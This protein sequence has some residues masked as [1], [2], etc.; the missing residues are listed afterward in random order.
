MQEFKACASFV[1]LTFFI[2][3]FVIVFTNNSL[4]DIEKQDPVIFNDEVRIPTS[5]DGFV[6]ITEE[7]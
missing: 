3:I 5:E 4:F 6:D 7:S 1:G 2:S